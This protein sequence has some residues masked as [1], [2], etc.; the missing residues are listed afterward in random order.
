M[1]HFCFP[2]CFTVGHPDSSLGPNL[3]SYI[4]SLHSVILFI[5]IFLNLFLNFILIAFSK[6]N[7]IRFSL[8]YSI[9]LVSTVQPKWIS[10][11]VYISPYF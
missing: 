8:L 2:P 3:T 9:V 7:F 10:Y 6:I 4:A 5:K 1:S 11:H